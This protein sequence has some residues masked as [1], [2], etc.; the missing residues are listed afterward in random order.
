MTAGKSGLIG[1]Y[2]SKRKR[3]DDYLKLPKRD[4]KTG[5]PLPPRHKHGEPTAGVPV[6][7]I[8]D[9]SNDPPE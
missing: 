2:K 8:P 9:N 1:G 4:P 7:A 5:D 6:L 3:R